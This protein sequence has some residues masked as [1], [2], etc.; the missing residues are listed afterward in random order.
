VA[1]AIRHWLKS[2]D[3]EA[4][5]ITPGSPWEN[6]FVESSHSRLRDE[7]LSTEVFKN[8]KA[9]AGARGVLAKRLQSPAAAQQPGLPAPRRVR[10]RLSGFHFGYAGAPARHRL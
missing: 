8:V 5:Y 2:A 3:V 4:L 9:C 1:K 10:R 7:C 6:G